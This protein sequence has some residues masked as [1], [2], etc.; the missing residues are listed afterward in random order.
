MLLFDSDYKEYHTDTTVR[1]VVSMAEDK[2]QKAL[3]DGMHKVFKLQGSMTTSTM[4]IV[5]LLCFFST[6]FIVKLGS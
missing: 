1:F 6:V 5:P 4:V 2:Y 3:A